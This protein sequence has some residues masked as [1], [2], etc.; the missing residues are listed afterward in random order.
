MAPPRVSFLK[1]LFLKLL[2]GVYGEARMLTRYDMIR[3]H[4]GLLVVG[5][6]HL[7]L[8][9]ETSLA[10]KDRIVTGIQDCSPSPICLDLPGLA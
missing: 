1:L 2:G 9:P 7:L 5:L 4:L 8:F 10:K 6:E 3:D